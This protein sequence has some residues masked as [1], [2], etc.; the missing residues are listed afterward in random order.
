M[1]KLICQKLNE[2]KIKKD[3]FDQKGFILQLWDNASQTPYIPLG[4]AISSIQAK[5]KTIAL[6]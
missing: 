2:K 3:S 6:I 5:M 1:D 4:P